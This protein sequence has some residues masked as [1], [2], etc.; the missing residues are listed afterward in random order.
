MDAIKEIEAA[1]AAGPS[2]DWSL[3]RNGH[4]GVILGGPVKQYTNGSS[5]SQ[6]V[7][8]CVTD[9]EENK[10]TVNAAYIHACNPANMRS[11]LQLIAARDAEIER[12]RADLEKLER[13]H[14]DKISLARGA[15]KFAAWQDFAARFDYS[16]RKHMSNLM[17][18]EWTICAI[19]IQS[20]YGTNNGATPERIEAKVSISKALENIA[21]LNPTQGANK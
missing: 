5:Q 6:I 9:G 2:E 12:L 1:L 17:A 18:H 4:L 14:A 3:S 8:T 11:I 13:I 15:A 10:Q 7:M 20:K 19:E 16:Q 21:A